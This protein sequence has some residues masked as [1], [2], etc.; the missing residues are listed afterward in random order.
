MI[1]DK[2]TIIIEQ[3]YFIELQR[4]KETIKLNQNKTMV[5]VNSA[6]IITYYEIGSII[7]ERKFGAINI[8]KDYLTTYKNMAKGTVWEIYIIWAN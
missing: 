6:M 5:V 3:E 1:K 4:I 2:E 8:L 7:N